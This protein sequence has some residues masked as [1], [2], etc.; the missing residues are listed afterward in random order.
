MWVPLQQGVKRLD[1]EPGSIVVQL[2]VLLPDHVEENHFIPHFQ[3]SRGTLSADVQPDHRGSTASLAKRF[4]LP[5]YYE[6]T[7][8]VILPC[9]LLHKVPLLGGYGLGIKFAG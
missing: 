9:N 3:D 8:H 7:C 6:P 5:R 1:M 4:L 2:L